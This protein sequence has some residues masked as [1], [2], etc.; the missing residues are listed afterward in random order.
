MPPP[1]SKSGSLPDSALNP[2]QNP[3]LAANLG[4][5]AEVYFTTPPPKRAEAIAELIRQLEI[6]NGAR[7]TINSGEGA[8]ASTEANVQEASVNTV[9]ESTS[10]PVSAENALESTVLENASQPVAQESLILCRGCGHENLPRQRFCGMCGVP[11]EARPVPNEQSPPFPDEQ[12]AELTPHPED[13]SPDAE[14]PSYVTGP[15]LGPSHG[16]QNESTP[17]Y[18]MRAADSEPARRT[19][20][21]DLPGFAIAAKEPSVPYRYRLYIGAALVILLSILIYM[22]WRGKRAFSGR[23]ASTGSPYTQPAPAPSQSRA[24]V[25]TQA[26]KDKDKGEDT[27]APTAAQPQPSN[28]QTAAG[29]PQSS[30]PQTPAVAAPS[31]NSSSAS[32]QSASEAQFAAPKP[33]DKPA[34]RKQGPGNAHAGARRDEHPITPAAAAS[35]DTGQQELATAERY[36]NG[37]PAR[38]SEQAVF[39]LWKAVG[40]GNVEATLTLSDLYLRG[41]GVPKNCDQARLLLDAAARK[42]DKDAAE[43][44]RNLPAFGCQ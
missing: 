26:A 39:W 14:L 41:D 33:A 31:Q 2:L 13:A 36:L 9:R 37:G 1:E 27:S 20:E 8:N 42:G 28:Q 5:W 34:T 25:P 32:E 38:D 24:V 17:E 18:H 4:R 16:Y 11:L 23:L 44:L 19:P 6:E 10:G 40:K 22:S 30:A 35:S 12:S 43:R 3:L 15:V 7:T 21:R 29:E